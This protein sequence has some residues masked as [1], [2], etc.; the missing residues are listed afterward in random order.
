MW[1]QLKMTLAK[2]MARLSPVLRDSQFV[3]ELLAGYN[4]KIAVLVTHSGFTNAFNVSGT[5][6]AVIHS[7]REF[8]DSAET[9]I[10]PLP[11]TIKPTDE[12]VEAYVTVIP[13]I[14]KEDVLAIRKETVFFHV[15][16]IVEYN[17]F[18]TDNRH[19]MPF[20][21]TGKINISDPGPVGESIGLKPVDHS[22]WEHRIHPEV[23][24][25]IRE[26]NQQYPNQ[27]LT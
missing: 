8:P 3:P 13:P 11:S 5:G 15:F 9:Y 20:W 6:A 16:G 1:E 21:Y 24:R 27:P 10:I 26:Y 12:Q 14:T 2:E 4:A 23:E 7:S 19:K 25:Q 22:Y 18:V 17:D